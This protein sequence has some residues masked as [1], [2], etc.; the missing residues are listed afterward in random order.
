MCSS[1]SRR[2]KNKRA[3]VFPAKAGIQLFGEVAS[4][5]QSWI[6]ASAG[7]TA[8]GFGVDA[9]SIARCDLVV[10]AIQKLDQAK[11]IAERIGERRNASP[12]CG[13]RRAFANCARRPGARDCSV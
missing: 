8:H 4:A 12:S 5:Y 6:P 2:R 7:M 13:S 10:A 1:R 11:P 9:T 3:L